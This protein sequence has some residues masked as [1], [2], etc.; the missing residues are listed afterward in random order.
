MLN[1]VWRPEDA[2]RACSTKLFLQPNAAT[3]IVQTVACSEIRNVFNYCLQ[4]PLGVCS[5]GQRCEPKSS[6]IMEG[7]ARGV[8]SISVG[9]IAR[10]LLLWYQAGCD[11]FAASVV[12]L[13]VKI[14]EFQPRRVKEMRRS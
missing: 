14:N 5:D 13:R 8:H 12:I 9:F 1:K 6:R 10:R 2:S 11:R 4:A 7:Q 3:E